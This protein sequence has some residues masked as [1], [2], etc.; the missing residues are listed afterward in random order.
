MDEGKKA[1]VSEAYELLREL[2]SQLLELEESSDDELLNSVFRTMHTI[3]GAS[4]MFGFDDISTLTHELETVFDL[5]RSGRM[6]IT[7]EL[8]DL[9]LASR[10]NIFEMLSTDD[11]DGEVGVLNLDLLGSIKKLIPSIADAVT[12]SYE[13]HGPDLQNVQERHDMKMYWIRFLPGKDLFMDGTNPLNLMRELSELGTCKIYSMVENIPELDDM[14]AEQCYTSW[15]AL[16]I[17]DKGVNAIKDVFIFV[18]DR[19]ELKIKILDETGGVSDAEQKKLGEILVENG[20]ITEEDLQKVL[21]KQRRLGEILVEEGVIS[22]RKVDSALLEQQHLKDMRMRQETAKEAL[23]VR[24]ASEKLDGLVD[25]VGELVT[26]Q[27][28]LSQFADMKD[29]A[30]LLSI[31][32]EVERLT[33]D[34]RESTMSIRMLPIGST[35]SKFRRLIRDLSGELGKEVNMTTEGAETELDKTVIEKLN[36]PLVHIIR[37]C[38]FHG[39]E[40][41][42][43]RYAKGKPGAGTIHLSAEHSGAHVLI[44][45]SDDGAGVDVEAVRRKAIERRLISEDDEL[46]NDETVSLIFAPGF[47]TAKEVTDVSGRGVGMDVVKKEMESLRGDIEIRTVMGEGTTITLKLPLTLAIIDGLLV[48]MAD[49]FYVLP[50][51][52]VEE[53]VELTGADIASSHGKHIADVRGEIVPYVRLRELFGSNGSKPDME[54]IVI[55]NADNRRVGFVVDHVIGEHQTVIKTLGRVFKNVDGVSGATILGDGTV[56]LILD[57]QKLMLYAE[58]DEL[59]TIENYQRSYKRGGS[60]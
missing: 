29:D 24:V 26:V 42:E 6:T 48:K 47:S 37:N 55:T 50:L 51:S 12:G 43:T 45:I 23:S 44:H 15:D 33:D 27:A 60:L 30:N 14:D 31:A 56:A 34:L 20:D 52:L 7:K 35:F 40:D 39:I 59:K 57:V 13:D 19:C 16:L 4:A 9:T 54:Q 11:T 58:E 1:F 21:T 18:E 38:L 28:R 8:I 22:S 36:D 32:E 53:C 17:T 25:L 3:K 41:P 5:V 49:S 10:D 2:E 46:T